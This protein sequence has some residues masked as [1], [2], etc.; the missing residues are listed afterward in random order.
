MPKLTHSRKGFARQ[1]AS[2]AG[3]RKK[4]RERRFM[5][6]PLWRSG[7]R[8]YLSILFGNRCGYCGCTLSRCNTPRHVNQWIADRE[9]L[10]H[11]HPIR[12]G[13]PDVYGNLMLCCHGCNT[14]KRS[15]PLEQW[16][17]ERW[18]GAEFYFERF[19]ADELRFAP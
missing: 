14:S 18:K 11:I 15:I 6:E 10:D 2:C 5:Q 1:P 8:A 4:R 3:N 7:R 19:S 17:R 16:R 9:T 12:L 13:G